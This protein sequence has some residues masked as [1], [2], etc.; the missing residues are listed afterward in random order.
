M[1]LQQHISV[2]GLNLG[3]NY[4]EIVDG[5]TDSITVNMTRACNST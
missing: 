2:L 4:D 5:S 1:C 3:T